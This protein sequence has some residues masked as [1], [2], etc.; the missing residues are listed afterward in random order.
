MKRFQLWLTLTV[1]MMLFG[2]RV[3]AHDIAVENDDGVTIYYVWTNNGTELAVSYKGT[4][5]STYKDEYTGEVVIPSSVLYKNKKYNVTSIGTS[6]FYDCKSLTSVTIPNSV[7]TIES[8]SFGICKGL[9]SITIPN[10]VTSIVGSAFSSC[11]GLTSITIPNSVTSMSN[12][13]FEGCTN[14]TTV[15]FHC[16]EI[17]NWFSSLKSSITT[18]IIG[19]EVITI[20]KSAFSGFINMASITIPNSVTSIG[21]SAFSGCTGLTSI[22]IP[23]SVTSIGGSAFSGCTN[24]STIEYHC[25]KI[26]NWFS[27]IGSSIRNVIIGNEVTSFDE[28]AFTN[29]KGIE[30]VTIANLDAWCKIQKNN[31]YY[32]Y[33]N[34]HPCQLYLNDKE[35]TNLVIPETVTSI[36]DYSFAYFTNIT[37]VTIPNSVT[38]IC[39]YAFSGCTG[40]T[41]VTIGNSVTSIGEHAFEGCA[42]LKTIEIPVSVKNIGSVAFG[43]TGLISLTIPEGVEIIDDYLCKNCDKLTSVSIPES[44]TKISEGAFFGCSKLPSITIPSNVESIFALAFA[45]CSSLKSVTILCPS[46]RDIFPD[47][48]EELILGEKVTEHLSYSNS[49]E[50]ISSV[51]FYCQTIKNWFAQKSN[52]KNITIGNTVTAIDR[53]A[54]IECTGLN[55]ITIPGNVKAIGYKAFY[56]CSGLSTI[57]IDEGVTSIDNSAFQNCTSLSSLAL[58]NSITTIGI[59]AFQGC[60][61]LKTAI[62]GDG[63]TNIQ[64]YAF[65]DCTGLTAIT[66]PRNIINISSSFQGCTGI[67]SVTFHCKKIGSWF[68]G[69][70][71]L[72]EI[73]FGDE[74]TTIGKRAFE[75][76]TGLTSIFIPE[77]VTSIDENAFSG[78][79]GLTSLTIPNSMTS[80]NSYTFYECSNLTS[81]DMGNRI[82][83]IREYAFGK[84]AN[85]NSIIFS[86]KTS[87]IENNAFTGVPMSEAKVRVTDLVAFCNNTTIRCLYNINK[88]LPIRLIDK[89]GA[90]ITDYTVPDDVKTIG[91]RAFLNCVGLTNVNTG[92]GVEL[93]S[94]AAFYGCYSINSLI[95]GKNLT[96]IGGAA[97]VDCNSL[98]EVHCYANQVPILD[99]TAFSNAGDMTLYVPRSIRAQYL[100]D[101]NWSKF[102]LIKGL[103][104]DGNVIEGR[105]V[106]LNLTTPGMLKTFA[107][108]DEGV[109]PIKKLT[110]SGKMNSLDLATLQDEVFA[111]LEY[112]NLKDVTLVADGGTYKAK[113]GVSFILSDSC[114][115]K[116]YQNPNFPDI[117]QY[118]YYSNN[119]AGAFIGV[120]KLKHVV[121]PT[122]IKKI[123]EWAF[124]NVKTIEKVDY[125]NDAVEIGH[126]AFSNSGITHLDIPS[127]VKTIGYSA[128]EN[129]TIETLD[130]SHIEFI[131]SSAFE[132]CKYFKANQDGVLDLALTDSIP[133][134]AFKNCASLEKAVLRKLSYLGKEAFSNCTNLEFVTLPDS[135]ELTNSSCFSGT[136]WFN[137]LPAEDGIVYWKNS[138][139]TYRG[140]YASTFKLKE[141]T[142]LLAEDFLKSGTKPE[143]VTSIELPFSLE[144]ISQNSLPSSNVTKLTIPENIRTLYA[145][146]PKVKTL[147]FN[148]KHIEDYHLSN[149]GEIKLVVGP[150]VEYLPQTGTV[151]LADFS[152]SPNNVPLTI[153]RNAFNGSL[154]TSISLPERTVSIEAGAFYQ[155]KNLPTVTIPSG[156]KRLSDNYENHGTFEQCTYLSS[157]QLPVGLEYIGKHCFYNCTNITSIVI[158]ETVKV[159][160]NGAFINCS[161]LKNVT[162]PE[163]LEKMDYCFGDCANLKSISIPKSVRTM[164]TSL[165]M[166][167]LEEVVYNAVNASGMLC[168]HSLQKLVIGPDVRKIPS[169]IYNSDF[170]IFVNYDSYKIKSH[171]NEVVF[172]ERLEGSKLT[173]GPSAFWNFA[174]S[175]FDIPDG[176]DSICNSAFLNAA[177]VVVTI[178]SSVEYV[179]AD[180]FKDCKELT[181]VYCLATEVPKTENNAFTTSCIKNA[182]LYIPIG[183]KAKYQSATAWKNFGN[184]VEMGTG[185]IN[186]TSSLGEAK[187]EVFGLNGHHKA[188]LTQGLNIIRQADGTVKKVYIK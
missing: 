114:Y 180:A 22:N 169:G 165:Y 27:Y 174:G 96:Q 104:D 97:F 64:S 150:N 53:N 82:E 140:E 66:I 87:T 134:Y 48:V 115:I 156:V 5:S 26:G 168:F 89:D 95:L 139:L 8:G 75:G 2:V 18:V 76:C 137:N 184:I 141:G 81:L 128:F 91:E 181:R 84:C 57:T 186:H 112:L 56:N 178:P 175:T 152:D 172:E 12:T 185:D 3:D 138:A 143:N 153:G 176:T 160:D 70:N 14:I 166:N 98:K 13:A 68:N 142:K 99:N 44:V 100:N 37:T 72:K 32:S 73:I 144:T 25:K 108:S 23:N 20:G 94:N 110:L 78:C 63:V 105:E 24:I 111:E 183:T 31:S 118:Y 45:G 9:K 159:M 88:Q 120:G 30:K 79:S 117:Q 93:I 151:V 164:E 58:P 122:S 11:T 182:T 146:C 85:L 148:A 106:T 126:G 80:I 187:D 38:S 34:N 125:A 1:L 136:L 15:E 154:L 4:S 50:N 129:S 133:N 171:A 121:M 46:F 55:S 74:V 147:T 51:T 163:G 67:E 69:F 40:L 65:Q 179:G 158:P 52:I 77:N 62:L 61:N 71:G 116:F 162:L 19:E 90:E 149:C 41:S 35:I 92:N 10:S 6:A 119:L 155:C 49:W 157:I 54:F 123:G 43:S 33:P 36:G 188:T 86:D 59:S 7:K 170:G 17:G 109:D 29:F 101:Q 60:S 177:I 130:M 131:G 113:A 124:Y 28:D 47:T 145:S 42:G 135:Y 102:G 173:I 16:S 83:T 167:D 21:G 127:T 107:F 39:T 161:N 103:D 132:D